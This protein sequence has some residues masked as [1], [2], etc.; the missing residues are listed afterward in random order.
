MW[1]QFVGRRSEP[2]VNWVER[3]AVRRFAL[4]IGD[5]HPLYLDEEAAGRSRWGG[6]IAPPTFPVTF[7]YG[8]IPGLPLPAAGLIH[9]EQR[10]SAARPL[11]VG[12]RLLCQTELKDAYEKQGKGGVLTF[13]VIDRQSR[14]AEG[15]LVCIMEAILIVTETVRRGMGR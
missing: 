8:T 4:A 6:L 1:E 13:L 11:R 3:G 12:E 10:I 2:V 5:P 15:S 14:D 7:E 9:G